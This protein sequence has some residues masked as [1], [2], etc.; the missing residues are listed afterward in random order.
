MEYLQH[1]VSYRL[2]V[3]ILSPCSHANL[4]QLR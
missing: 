4:S 3:E 1:L 2:S